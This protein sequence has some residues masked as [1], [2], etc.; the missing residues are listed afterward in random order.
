MNVVRPFS[1]GETSPPRHSDA[2]EDEPY[3]LMLTQLS[4]AA[5]V[6]WMD[7]AGL[8]SRPSCPVV[9]QDDRSAPRSPVP[10]PTVAFGHDRPPGSAGPSSWM[11]MRLLAAIENVP[12][13]GR[14]RHLGCTEDRA[15]GVCGPAAPGCGTSGTNAQPGSD[16]RDCTRTSRYAAGGRSVPAGRVRWSRGGAVLRSRRPPPGRPGPFGC[17]RNLRTSPAFTR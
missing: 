8:H 15:A 5:Q 6:C 14:P 9:H 13:S 17:G 2:S 3:R 4:C 16:G 11:P 12:S 7:R 1:L 10:P